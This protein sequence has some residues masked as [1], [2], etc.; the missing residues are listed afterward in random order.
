MSA[1]AVGYIPYEPLAESAEA[2][3]LARH[4]GLDVRVAP[5]PSLNGTALPPLAEL[6][7][8]VAGVQALGS[9][10]LEGPGG[11]LWAAVLRAHGFA[12]SVT[13]LPYLNPHRW[14]DVAAVALY[15]RFAQPGDHVFLGSGP[16]AAVYA[17]C[18]IGAAVGEPYGIDDELFRLRPEAERTRRELGIPPGRMLLFAGRAERD[19]DLYRLLR[20]GVKAQLLFG[21]LQLVIAS[22]VVDEA[23]LAA[24]RERLGGSAGVHF[25]TGLGRE[26]LADLYSSADAF[27]TASTSHF[28]TFGRAPAEALACGTAAIAPRYDGFA[29]VL[30]QP[31]GTL[32]DLDPSSATP[33]VDEEGLLRAVYDTLSAPRRPAAREVSAAARRRLGRSHT[34]R[35][36]DYLAG[37]AARRPGAPAGPPTPEL[38]GAWRR[39]LGEIARRPPR[40]ALA[41]FWDGCDHGRLGAEDAEFAGAVRRSLCV[42]AEGAPCR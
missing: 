10:V 8:A 26:Q 37:R 18:G 27:V 25:V 2:G 39:P 24:A 35:L 30:D 13:V 4:L 16:S 22:H 36:L 19:K 29:E 34:I 12:G 9:A 11:F 3:W 20:V 41:W 7:R 1:T 28:E 40:E 42:P 38:P 14:R 15:R 21:D 23:Y 5:A 6:P 17:S 33:A 32:V 31:G